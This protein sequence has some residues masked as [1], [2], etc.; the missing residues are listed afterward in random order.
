MLHNNSE[1]NLIKLSHSYP[2]LVKTPTM[3][4]KSTG[5]KGHTLSL[6]LIEIVVS[7]LL[8]CIFGF[9]HH[10]VVDICCLLR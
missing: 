6:T 9:V 4:S 10:F 3:K 2:L 7:S 1:T 8:F 5:W